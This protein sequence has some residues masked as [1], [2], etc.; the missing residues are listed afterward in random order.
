M[1]S[2]LWLIIGMCLMGVIMDPAYLGEV[3]H[4]IGDLAEQRQPIEIK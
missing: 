2:L 4:T 3:F 1:N